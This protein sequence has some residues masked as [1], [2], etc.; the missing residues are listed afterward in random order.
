MAIMIKYISYQSVENGTYDYT[1]KSY[2]DAGKAILAVASLLTNSRRGM[3]RTVEVAQDGDTTIV[4]VN[5]KDTRANVKP[6][7]VFDELADI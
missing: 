4:T 6:K 1:T 7:K 5:T 3:P 2:D